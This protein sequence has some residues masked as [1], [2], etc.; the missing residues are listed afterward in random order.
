MYLHICMQALALA[1][2]PLNKRR[3]YTCIDQRIRIRACMCTPAALCTALLHDG[4]HA[5][6]ALVDRADRA[7][8]RRVF[9]LLGLASGAPQTDLETHAPVH[10]LVLEC[11]R[12]ADGYLARCAFRDYEL[13]TFQWLAH[14]DAVFQLKLWSPAA[15][16]ALCAQAPARIESLA[17]KLHALRRHASPAHFAGRECLLSVLV[18]RA[19]EGVQVR[20]A[21]AVLLQLFPGDACRWRGPQAES[22]FHRLAQAEAAPE[23]LR[24]FEPLRAHALVARD[25]SEGHTPLQIA[26]ACAVEKNVLVF[27]GG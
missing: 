18:A 13:R 27:F 3:R 9:A 25:D 10:V 2:N 4:A 19:H 26:A 1:V 8:L 11:L 5:W 6:R 16:V 23:L 14:L 15:L 24:V 20:R 22:V 17:C 7:E 12:A 21:V